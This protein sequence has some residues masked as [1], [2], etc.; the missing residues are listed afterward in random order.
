MPL[1][2]P[3]EG[4]WSVNTTTGAIIFTPVD[5]YSGDPTPIRYTVA[6][7]QGNRSNEATVTVVS[8]GLPEVSL[9]I[10]VDRMQQALDIPVHRVEHRWAGLRSFTP[11][12]GLAIGACEVPGFFWL[13]GQGGYGIQTAPA[14]GRLIA[15]LV[16]GEE[17]DADLLPAVAPTNPLRFAA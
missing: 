9:A 2:V 15:Q 14:A 16:R 13:C 10:A 5:G 17:P 7:D 11:D 4:T 12:R 1:V 8:A 6:D 3:G